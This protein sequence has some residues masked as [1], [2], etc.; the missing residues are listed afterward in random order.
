MAKIC[1]RRILAITQALCGGT[2]EQLSAAGD[3]RIN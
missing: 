1:Q 2:G 3:A